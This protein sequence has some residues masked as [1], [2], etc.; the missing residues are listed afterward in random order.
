MNLPAY[1]KPGAIDTMSTMYTDQA[2][3]TLNKEKNR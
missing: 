2:I 1:Y 3:L